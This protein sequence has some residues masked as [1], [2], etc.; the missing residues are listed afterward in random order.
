MV[1]VQRSC[2]FHHKPNKE[3]PWSFNPAHGAASRVS[4]TSGF[5]SSEHSK[6][7]LVI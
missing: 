4:D 2:A 7:G 3:Q 5:F 1:M 6:N